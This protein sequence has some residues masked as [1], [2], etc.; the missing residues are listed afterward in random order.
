MVPGLVS[1]LWTPFLNS[2]IT[3]GQVSFGL[4]PFEL[5]SLVSAGAG[6]ALLSALLHDAARA[7]EDVPVESEHFN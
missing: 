3:K 5:A 4:G 7:E 6:F 1:E 2:A